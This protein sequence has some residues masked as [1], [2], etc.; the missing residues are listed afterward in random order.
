MDIEAI[1]YRDILERCK[2][3]IAEILPGL[4]K[5]NTYDA[6]ERFRDDLEEIREDSHCY[7]GDAIGGW[8]W[9]IYTHYGIKILYGLPLEI[10]R[11]AESEFFDCMGGQPIDSLNDAF[12][13]A[14]RI[15]YYALWII[16]HGTLEEMAQELIDLA[17]TQLENKESAQ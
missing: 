11:Q 2:G 8:D 16:F 4:P 14:S 13:M 6:W 9:A 15:A 3:D 7:A 1:K 10:E 5:E 17:E 12:D